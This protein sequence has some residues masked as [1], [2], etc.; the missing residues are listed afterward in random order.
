MANGTFTPSALVATQ[1]AMSLLVA[2][3]N[4]PVNRIYA[5]KS[6]N[7]VDAMMNEQVIVPGKVQ[8]V[9]K[10]YTVDIIWPE[11]TGVGGTTGVAACDL[12]SGLEAGTYKQSYTINEA[13]KLDNA[14]VIDENDLISNVFTPEQVRA[15]LFLQAD[16]IMLDTLQAKALTFL[17]AN[18]MDTAANGNGY[19]TDA[20]GIWVPDASYNEDLIADIQIAAAMNKLGGYF[21]VTGPKFMRK[22]ILAG[23]KQANLDGKGA[24]N[25]LTGEN[26]YFDAFNI[27]ALDNSPIFQVANTSF[28][29]VKKNEHST[30]VQEITADKKKFTISSALMPGLEYDVI[31]ERSCSAGNKTSY[32]YMFQLR[33]KL[34]LHPQSNNA[35]TNKGI[36]KWVNGVPA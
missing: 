17:N 32:K 1:A 23:A 8:E 26:F 22:A 13:T 20:D 10:D 9:G 27:T 18:F 3:K 14:L 6:W 7:I 19:P 11:I 34:I 12:G 24:Y 29:W 35:S 36:I 15:Q 2:D 30:A 4:S 31:E 25:L 33:N 5:N 28:C 21:L 16:S